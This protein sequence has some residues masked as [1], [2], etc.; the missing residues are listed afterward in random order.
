F[1][2]IA[3]RFEAQ[4]RRWSASSLASAGARL[5]AADAACKRTGAK[6]HVLRAQAL[7]AVAGSAPKSRRQAARHSLSP[8]ELS[9]LA[10]PDISHSRGLSVF[11]RSAVIR[12]SADMLALRGPRR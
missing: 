11:R 10:D 3:K 5:L 7:L 4:A 9:H 8:F 12:R 1:W 6:D 2:K